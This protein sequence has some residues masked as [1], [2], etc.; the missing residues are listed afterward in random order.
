MAQDSSK[1][2]NRQ[3]NKPSWTVLYNIVT[4]GSPWIGTGWEFFDDKEAAQSCYNHQIKI[5]NCPTMRP[6]YAGYKD[7]KEFDYWHLG[8]AHRM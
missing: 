3:M 8:A 5:G 7:S 4:P 2:L 6:Y 1:R